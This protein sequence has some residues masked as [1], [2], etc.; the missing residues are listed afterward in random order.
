MNHWLAIWRSYWSISFSDCPLLRGHAPFPR[1]LFWTQ[2]IIVTLLQSL[3]VH[4]TFVRQRL[5]SSGCCDTSEPE[6]QS[7]RD[8]EHTAAIVDGRNNERTHT[9]INSNRHSQLMLT[10]EQRRVNPLLAGLPGR[11]CCK[12]SWPAAFIWSEKL[13]CCLSSLEI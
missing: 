9:H 4:K 3:T 11:G 13:W 12:E 7:C 1:V 2:C 10:P 5:K 6:F 8:A